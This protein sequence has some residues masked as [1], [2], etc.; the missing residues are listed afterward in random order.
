MS[1]FDYVQYDETAAQQQA[2]IKAKFIELE[3]V[4]TKLPL[5]REVS[6]AITKLEEAYMRVG[7]AIRDEQI[8]RN[9]ATELQEQRCN[10]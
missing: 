3:V 5:G 10:S 1:R 2:E 8:I 7:R 9:A 6:L 4:I